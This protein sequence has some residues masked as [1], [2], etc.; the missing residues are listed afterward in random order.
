M[1]RVICLMAALCLFC[2]FLNAGAEEWSA[3]E[4]AKSI[5]ADI[6]AGNF[7]PIEAQVDASVVS[8]LN[9]G[10]I[11]EG[12]EAICAML[13]DFDTVTQ[14]GEME[15]GGNM[16][17][18]ALLQHQNG[19]QVFTLVF[20]P[21]HLLIGMQM[22]PMPQYE[23]M[24][25]LP[26]P[27]QVTEEEI[28]LRPGQA[29]ETGGV[30]MI[31]AREEKVPAVVLIHGSGASDRDETV[32]GVKPF[33]DIAV[34]LAGHGIATLRY[35]KYTYA[36]PEANAD[37]IERE[38]TQ[39]VQGAV[40]LLRA[41]ERIGDIYLLGHSEGGML[42]PRLLL[43]S[44]DAVAG[45]II[46]A[47]T[48]RSLWEVQQMQNEDAIAAMPEEDK[49][50]LQAVIDAEVE[51]GLRLFEMSDE[52]LASELVFG[53]P[54]SYHKDIASVEPIEMAKALA[55]P[56]LILQG[57]KD[58]QVRADIDYIAWQA[59][60]GEETFVSFALYPELTHLFIELQGEATGTLEDYASGGHV[61]TVVTDDIA[62]WIG[63]QGE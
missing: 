6:Q 34:G 31:P 10:T 26:L 61:A 13:G 44:G 45:G 18:Q 58:F 41:D 4:A 32:Y 25:L 63:E 14:E 52:E 5:M 56:L 8:M 16:I 53:V 51:K 33:R 50:A 23:E 12:W 39:D 30:L 35:D 48:P 37:T 9:A 27:E 3:T 46:L 19:S 36:H 59:G 54:A 62:R 24:A 21:E 7:E 15:Q 60:L 40:A 1:K 38:Y 57:R 22:Q 20:S 42:I 49:T 17:Y 55:L 29:D 28:A 2:S 11:R 43:A 47:G